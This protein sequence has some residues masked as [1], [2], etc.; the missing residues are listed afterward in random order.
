MQVFLLTVEGRNS[1]TE[2]YA[3]PTEA[4]RE[5]KMWDEIKEAWSDLHD[6][7]VPDDMNVAIEKFK[8]GEGPWFWVKDCDFTGKG[9]D[10]DAMK[11]QNCDWHGERSA[12]TYPVASMP[13]LACC[14]SCSHHD[15]L[16]PYSVTIVCGSCGSDDVTRDA[17]VRWDIERQRWEL[18]N[19][20]DNG[21]CNACSGHNLEEK[22]A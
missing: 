9:Q 11:C 4:E 15:G 17:T 3:Y 18:S 6:G 19:V 13:D 22:P 12:L 14:P 16:E 10:V 8:D 1:G 21:D 20:L 5:S 2:I 7:P